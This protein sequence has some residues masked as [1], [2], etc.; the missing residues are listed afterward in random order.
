MAFTGL[1][2]S[3]AMVGDDQDEVEGGMIAEAELPVKVEGRR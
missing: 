1:V 3:S 2:G